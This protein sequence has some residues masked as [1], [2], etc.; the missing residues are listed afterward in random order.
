[1]NVPAFAI[2]AFATVYSLANRLSV[3]TADITIFHCKGDL[4]GFAAY[5]AILDVGLA[6][7]RKAQNHG[8]FFAAAW[9]SESC[10]TSA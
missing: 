3:E 10:S 2:P 8:N 4:D 7:D 6:T 5:L 9:T 1:M